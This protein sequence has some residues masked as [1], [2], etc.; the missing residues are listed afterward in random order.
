MTQP[1]FKK[2]VERFHTSLK[3]VRGVTEQY[4]APSCYLESTVSGVLPGASCA[5]A[6]ARPRKPLLRSGSWPGL[7]QLPPAS[8]ARSSLPR[9]IRCG[10]EASRQRR[11]QRSSPE[12]CA[13][14]SPR[15]LRRREPGA[16]GARQVAL[17]V[18]GL[19]SGPLS[20][21]SCSEKN[22]AGIRF[23]PH[24]GPGHP[25]RA[26][27]GPICLVPFACGMGDSVSV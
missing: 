12:S 26:V 25:F 7:A 17:G 10:D 14:P 18:L 27:L 23:G 19:A 16:S 21:D 15:P 11:T 2:R 24:Q 5:G 1:R 9:R 22:Q 3:E 20:A 13:S 6:P 4:C 8:C